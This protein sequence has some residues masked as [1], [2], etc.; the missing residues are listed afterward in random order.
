MTPQALWLIPTAGLLVL[1]LAVFGI[2]LS[3]R[4]QPPL[5]FAQVLLA[6]GISGVLIWFYADLGEAREFLSIEVGYWGSWIGVFLVGFGAVID[7]V[8][9]SSGPGG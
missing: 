6:L 9:V 1:A 4:W 8:R 2:F 5:L 7:M 3:R